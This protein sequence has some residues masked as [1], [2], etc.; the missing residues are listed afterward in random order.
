MMMFYLEAIV[1][2]NTMKA[3]RQAGYSIMS[4]TLCRIGQTIQALKGAEVLALS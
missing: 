2:T 1:I 3:N 4:D